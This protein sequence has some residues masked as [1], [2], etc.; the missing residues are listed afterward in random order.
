LDYLRGHGRRTEVIAFRETTSHQ[1]LEEAD[2]FTN[3]SGDKKRF[4]LK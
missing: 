2:D 3:L 1:L 4:L